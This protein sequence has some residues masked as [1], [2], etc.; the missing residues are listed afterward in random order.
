VKSLEMWSRCWPTTG[1]PKA[2]RLD[3][4]MAWLASLAMFVEKYNVQGIEPQCTLKAEDSL[5]QA[6]AYVH[7]NLYHWAVKWRAR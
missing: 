4:K 2:D 6:K 3:E 5:A 1:G 7:T